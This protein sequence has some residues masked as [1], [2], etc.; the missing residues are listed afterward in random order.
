MVSDGSWS[1]A[2]GWMR[3][4]TNIYEI[5]NLYRRVLQH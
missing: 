1:V 3:G 2:S 4:L 5:N